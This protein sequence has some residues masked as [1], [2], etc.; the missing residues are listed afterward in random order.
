[1]DLDSPRVGCLIFISTTKGEAVNANKPTKTKALLDTLLIVGGGTGAAVLV[2]TLFIQPSISS[3]TTSSVTPYA[4]SRLS[5]RCTEGASIIYNHIEDERQQLA[6]FTEKS[7]QSLATARQ[8]AQ[9]RQNS[10][11][12]NVGPGINYQGLADVAKRDREETQAIIEKMEKI[13]EDGKKQ[14]TDSIAT[15]TEKYNKLATCKRLT[16]ERKDI[17]DT[18]VIEYEAL[19]SELGR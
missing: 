6:D 18:A 17:P 15:D 3:S 14:L 16:L 1:M 13:V 2:Y 5:E 12:S 19:L 11:Y 7:E 4:H 9:S 10:I 8:T